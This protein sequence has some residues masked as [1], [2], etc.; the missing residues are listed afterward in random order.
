MIQGGG[1]DYFASIRLILLEAKLGGDPLVL[2][3]IF[4]KNLVEK[5][6]Y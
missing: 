5:P 3:E 6:P 1:V 4:L 2:C